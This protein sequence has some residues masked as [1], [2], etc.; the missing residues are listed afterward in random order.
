LQHLYESKRTPTLGGKPLLDKGNP[1]LVLR[2]LALTGQTEPPYVEFVGGDVLPGLVVG[3]N[4]SGELTTT[5]SPAVLISTPYS[6]EQ[7][8]VQAEAIK[9][10]V[11]ADAST[12]PYNPGR[13]E[14]RNGRSFD[15][16]GARWSRDGVKV[17]TKQGFYRVGFSEI[18]QFDLPGH[19]TPDD[20]LRG[21]SLLPAE[22]NSYLVRITTTRGGQF[23][24]P[25]DMALWRQE[26]RRRGKEEKGKWLVIQ[27][28]WALDPLYAPH[29]EIVSHSF[30]RP[31]QIPVSLLPVVKSSGGGGLYNWPWRRNRNVLG[32]PLT[33]GDVWADLGIGSHAASRI[34]FALPQGARAFET[35]VGLDRAAGG[36]GCVRCRIYVDGRRDPIWKSNAI[37]GS[38]RVLRVG[39]LDIGGAKTLTLEVDPAHEDRPQGADPLDVRDH[40]NWLLPTLSVALD[41]HTDFDRDLIW[42]APELAGWTVPKEFRDRFSLSPYWDQNTGRWFVATDCQASKWRITRKITIGPAN[43]W[44][45]LEVARGKKGRAAAELTVWAGETRIGSTMNGNVRTEGR[46]GEFNSRVY[47]LGRHAGEPITLAIQ[48]ESSKKKAQH[49]AP[50]VWSAAQPVPVVRGLPP[51]GRPI[52]A[53]TPLASLRPTSTK[54]ENLAEQLKDGKGAKGDPLVLRG[55]RFDRGYIVPNESEITFR[56]SPTW[57]RFVAVIGVPAHST[58]SG[59]YEILLNGQVHWSDAKA[60][61][62]NSPC[63]QIDVEIPPGHKTI[64]LRVKGRGDRYAAWAAAGFMSK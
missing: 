16:R 9:R 64:T 34:T 6:T 38:Q 48:V 7:I 17:L 2:N 20:L 55:L 52:V 58:S 23:T 11:S 29:Q 39:P 54:P 19:D 14:L 62:R 1:A 27:P 56:L 3:A 12:S 13:L 57:R 31:D 15:V 40:A 24:F 8:R 37:V 22:G 47:P 53:E 61:G 18:R 36:G 60:Y 28:A 30:R 26:L 32:G 10:I 50:I 44:L 46:L 42:W 41:K 43:A 4:G 59:P 25:Y 33:S 5:P 49:V 21:A 63:R 35:L 51:G 45:P